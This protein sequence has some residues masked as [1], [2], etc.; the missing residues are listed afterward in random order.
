[1]AES[2]STPVLPPLSLEINTQLM[3]ST[4]V[5]TAQPSPSPSNQLLPSTTMPELSITF[6]LISGRRRTMS[7]ASSTTIGRVKELVWNSWPADWSDER[8]PAPNFLRVLYLG[9]LLQDEEV[10][11]STMRNPFSPTGP[12]GSSLPSSTS[13]TSSAAQPYSTIFHLSVRPVPPPN[14]TDDLKKKKR[15]LGSSSSGRTDGDVEQA[16]CCASCIIC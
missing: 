8:P 2:T 5:S 1:M 14:E 3:D 16:S 4:N 6:L 12:G 15:R 11:E 10:L 13:P 9:K 7:F